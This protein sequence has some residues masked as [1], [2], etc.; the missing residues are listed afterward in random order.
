MIARTT[1]VR[2]IDAIAI[3]VSDEDREPGYSGAVLI[4]VSFGSEFMMG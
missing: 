2:T 3:P 4:V 1:V